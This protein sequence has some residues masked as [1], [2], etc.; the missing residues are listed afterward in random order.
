[1]REGR[2]SLLRKTDESPRVPLAGRNGNPVQADERHRRIFRPV[3][4]ARKA[5]SGTLSSSARRKGPVEHERG[6]L[7]GRIRID[8]HAEVAAVL[9]LQAI[10]Y[11]LPFGGEPGSLGE[12]GAVP[13]L[14]RPGIDD[15]L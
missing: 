4:P 1:M 12:A 9:L 2:E 6:V 5:V 10:D 8:S 14:H 13:L 7:D 3:T 15:E 11:L